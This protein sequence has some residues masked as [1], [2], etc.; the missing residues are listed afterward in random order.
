MIRPS[1]PARTVEASNFSMIAGRMSTSFVGCPVTVD[2]AVG[3]TVMSTIELPPEPTS[4]GVARRFVADCLARLDGAPT[5]V[6][7]L[8]VSELV[9]NAVLHARTPM[10]VTVN[11]GDDAVRVEVQDGSPALPTLRQYD[12]RAPTGRGLQ[13]VERLAGRWGVD[14]GDG[15]KTV[16]FELALVGDVGRE[17]SADGS[18]V[19]A[20][21]R[22]TSP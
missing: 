16:W 19:G 20:P 8:L 17:P 13:M 11:V 21:G 14:A 18:A 3:V 4:P 5:D 10:T 12:R 6:V 7:A 2:A 22:V 9:T 15:S 1:P